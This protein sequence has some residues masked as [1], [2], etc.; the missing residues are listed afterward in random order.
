MRYWALWLRV[1]FERL[2]QSLGLIGL[3]LLLAWPVVADEKA[4]EPSL[5]PFSASDT[6]RLLLLQGSNTLG[7]RLAPAW[8]Q[9]YLEARGARGV[10]IKPLAAENELRVSGRYQGRELFIDV[11]AHGSGTGYAGLELNQADI[12]LSSR[13]IKDQEVRLLAHLGDMRAATA[14]HIVAID[15]LAIITHPGNRL[16]RLSREQLST[17]FAGRVTDW[18]SLGGSPGPIRLYARDDKSGTFDSFMSLVM[19]SG[20]TLSA[21]AKRFES[22]DKLV[23]EVAAD[24]QAIGFVGLAYVKAVK[25]IAIFDVDS[26]PLTPNTLT[27]AT[28]DYVLSRRLFCYVNPLATNPHV[29][30]FIDFAQSEPGQALVAKQGFISQNPLRLQAP[31]AYGP[32]SY[33]KLSQIGERLSINFR[34]KPGQANLDN[35][36][37]EDVARIAAYLKRHPDDNRRLQLVGFSNQD[38][39]GVLSRLRATEVKIALYHYGLSTEP[40]WGLGEQLAVASPEGLD[41]PRNDRVEVWLYDAQAAAAIAPD[42]AE[43]TE[44]AGLL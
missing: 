3:G 18:S 39:S 26:Q 40:V 42:I 43:P 10:I 7:A 36:A 27:V 16:A 34:F 21:S 4:Q 12:A 29:Q 5:P 44:Q 11:H 22:S 14:E 23:A 2:A 30:A 28:E 25:P 13:P 37:L 9:A 6:G 1:G 41:A 31:V 17:I 38:E 19:P 32:L 15:G 8:A 33:Q 20:T 24:A 35:K